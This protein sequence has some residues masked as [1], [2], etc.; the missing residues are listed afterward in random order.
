QNRDAMLSEIRDVVEA[1]TV[2]D[3]NALR[4]LISPDAN[5][6]CAYAVY[7]IEVMMTQRS[8]EFAH[9]IDRLL[10]ETEEPTTFFV[11]IGIAHLL[12]A[13]GNTLAVLESQGHTINELWR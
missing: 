10:R 3:I 9:E 13:H 5:D 2:Q 1:Y 11:T 8:G 7:M 6:D 4:R 12:H